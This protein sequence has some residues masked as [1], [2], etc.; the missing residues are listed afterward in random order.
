MGGDLLEAS[1]LK[2]TPHPEKSKH[3]TLKTKKKSNNS[4]PP[5]KQNKNKPGNK[6]INKKKKEKCH[7]H[8][9]SFW[10]RGEKGLL[11]MN[12]KQI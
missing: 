7:V 1:I 11:G 12:L 3:K 5:N 9:R 8:K 10:E 4:K 2:I 6:Q